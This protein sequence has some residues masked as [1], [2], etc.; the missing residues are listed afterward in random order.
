MLCNQTRQFRHCEG[1]RAGVGNVSLYFQRWHPA[2]KQPTAATM[3]IVHGLGS[4]SGLFQP[5]VNR[6]LTQNYCVYAFDLR[7]HGRS[8]GQRGYINRWD[9]YR[10]DVQQFV[11]WVQWQEGDRPCYLMG[12]SLGAAIALDYSLQFPDVISGLILSAPALSTQGISPLKLKA[13]K[14]LSVVHPHFSLSTGFKK[15]Q[16]STRDAAVNE[17]YANDPLRHSRGTARLSTEFL[18]TNQQTWQNIGELEL[19]TLILQG[20]DD[21]VAPVAVT[22]QFFGRMPGENKRLYVYPGGYHDICND[23]NRE[24]VIGDVTHWL[25]EQQ[26]GRARVNSGMMLSSGEVRVLS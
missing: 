4:H 9:E 13:G 10:D 20:S 8:E 6:L 3:V 26:V 23:I 5:L 2:Q 15:K 18:K 14:L 22:R 12:N 24:Q 25:E 19:P 16:P 11:N 1:W 21:A 17:A 7:G